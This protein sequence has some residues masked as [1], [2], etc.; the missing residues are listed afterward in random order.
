MKITKFAWMFG[1][2]AAV[3][4]SAAVS[5]TPV[6]EGATEGAQKLYN[7]LA[8]NYGVK[9]VSGV[10]TGDVSSATVKELPDVIS[11]QEHTGKLP[12]L[13]GFDFLFAT[14]VKASDSWYQSYT[15]MAL[16]AAKDLW[17][18]GGI[19]AFTW[20][21]KDPSD[22]IDAFY[23]KSG[24]DKEYTEFDFT[25][26]F[27]DPA[28][29]ANCTWNKE[30]ETYKQ[31]VSDIDEI[32]D[33]F[34][35][36]QEAGV[37]AIFRPLHEAS[38][39]WFWWGTKGG[40]A[41]QALYNLVYDEM[42]GVKGVKN[43]VWVWNPEYTSDKDW[44]P[45]A[46]KY[47]VISLDIYEAWDYTTK[48]TKAYAELTT[49]Y[50]T[51][52]ILAVSENGSIPDMSAMKAGN[53]V[54]SWWMPW[55]QTWDGKFLDQ[56]VEA[57]WKANMESPCTI[58][59]ESMPGWDKYTVSTTP[60]AACEAGYKLGDLDTVRVI[61]EVLPGDMATNGWLQVK[62]AA[63]SDTAKGNIV[64]LD[65]NIPDLSTAKTLTMKVY[66]TN[67]MSGIWFTVAFLT[68]AP[69]WAWAQPDGCWVN[70]GDS[71]LCEIDLTTTAKDQVV[72]EGADYT[73][74]MG[75]ISKVYLEVFAAGFNGTVYYDDVTVDGSILINNF[76][77]KQTIKVEEGSNL[78]ATVIPPG[79]D[80]VKTVAASAAK[81]GIQGNTISL[82]TAKAGMVSVDVFGL[83]GKRVATLYKGNLAAG[84]YAFSLENMPKGSYI[85]RV[86]GAGIAA[87]KPVLVK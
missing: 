7:F 87:T 47:D 12:A 48:Y 17:S 11:F 44:N 36:L 18:Q 29:T 76:D 3:S 9:T 1:L 70:A 31:L 42:V 27:A 45:G 33:M 63:G 66:N 64:I 26:G 25:K 54:W 83:N 56:T 73:A 41:F 6:T 35:G 22:Q 85:V 52:K 19:P 15:Q 13:V 38:G 72:L 69:D 78:T 58:D 84:S 28:C 10:M 71:T 43:L 37:A 4:A 24:N 81:F 53:T 51:D 39:K 16:D 8:M 32:A 21:W 34:L 68:G 74:F 86:K 14:G 80:A 55:Y 77:K 59:L 67:S 60:V 23:T 62:L 75:N 46:T 57:V 5:A 30:S 82:S 20:H 2:A 65:K 61:E 50:G 40:A 49:N 79:T